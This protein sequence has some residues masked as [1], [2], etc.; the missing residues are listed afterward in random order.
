MTLTGLASALLGVALVTTTILVFL[1]WQ[2]AIQPGTNGAMHRSGL[3]QPTQGA[4]PPEIALSSPD[5]MRPKQ[6]RRLASP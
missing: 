2:G 1:L 6:G 3:S 4:T 5:R